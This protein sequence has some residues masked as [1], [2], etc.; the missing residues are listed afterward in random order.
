MVGSAPALRLGYRA[1]Q[2]VL[3]DTMRGI[4]IVE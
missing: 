2:P 4:A 3:I 1:A